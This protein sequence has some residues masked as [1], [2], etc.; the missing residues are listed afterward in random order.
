MHFKQNY[1]KWVVNR[2]CLNNNFAS[3]NRIKK[4]WENC[5]NIIFTNFI[6][7]IIKGFKVII[8][9]PVQKKANNARKESQTTKNQEN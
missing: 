8:I 4:G 3:N 9:N 6:K 5:Y 7:L 2:K 1:Q